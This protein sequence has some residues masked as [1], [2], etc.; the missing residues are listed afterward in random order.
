MEKN[1]KQ[2]DYN[3]FEEEALQQLKTGN[4]LEGTDGILVLFI[5]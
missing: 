4:C 1:K 2:F 3:K 5:V